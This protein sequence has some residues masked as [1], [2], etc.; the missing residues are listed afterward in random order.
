VQTRKIADETLCGISLQAN[1]EN[2]PGLYGIIGKACTEF[3]YISLLSILI[4]KEEN[5]ENEKE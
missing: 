4:I 2:G 3:P 5:S 1:P